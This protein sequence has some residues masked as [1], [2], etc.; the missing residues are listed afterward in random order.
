MNR[1]LLTIT[2]LFITLIAAQVNAAQWRTCNGNKIKWGS[3]TVTMR[4][5]IPTVNSVIFQVWPSD[6]PTA[7]IVVWAP[8]SDPRD[9]GPERSFRFRSVGISLLP[10]GGAR[11]TS[12]FGAAARS[13]SGGD[14][15]RPV[16]GSRGR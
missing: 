3:N 15:R 11:P 6:A 7:S 14:R 13:S 2:A 4:A 16:C 12:A 10:A 9:G 5:S 1:M 8:T